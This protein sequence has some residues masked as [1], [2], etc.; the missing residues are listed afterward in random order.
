[1][2]NAIYFQKL[3]GTITRIA[4]HSYYPG[5]EEAV[6]LCLE[7]IEE[8]HDCGRINDD[9]LANLRAL[10]IS[11]ETFCV[12]DDPAR[13]RERHEPTSSLDRI[14]LVCQG[15]GSQAAFTAGVLQGL[16]GQV[17]CEG[18]I[19]ALAGTSYGGLCALLAWDGLLRG[20]PEQSI[21]KL[22]RFWSEYSATSVI[23]ALIN[24]S[25]QM[26]LQFRSMVPLPVLGLHE[27]TAVGPD[28]LRRMLERQ[29]D[30]VAAREL[31][32]RL[33]APG[34]VVGSADDQGVVKICFGTELCVETMQA[35]AGVL[36]QNPTACLD[37]PSRA[38][39]TG[40]P[41]SPIRAV[42]R[43]RPSEIWLIEVKKLRRQRP[44][45]PADQ[46]VELI[47]LASSQLLE[48]ELRFIEKINSLLERGT[49]TDGDY[50]PMEVHRI[51]MEHDLDETSK[52]DRSVGFLDALMAY[53]RERAAQFLEKR[54]RQFV[55]ASPVVQL[56]Q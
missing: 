24:Y 10:L 43:F 6:E 34:L 21:D 12:L 33:G 31:A 37:S 45:S 36:P 51:V 16:L 49:L 50:R 40:L 14:A 28:Q 3:L 44:S 22:E 42:A 46:V 32:A 15:T 41:C 18:P 53:G 2:D 56:S 52:L 23:D 47:E 26:V 7:E 48:Q 27:V 54:G 55:S 11:E 9:Q 17:G 4:G 20:K 8:L 13:R 38:S 30:F 19:V 29:V 39:N 1:M 25:S 35:A 5:K